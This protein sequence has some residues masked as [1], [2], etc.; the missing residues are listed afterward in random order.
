MA[1]NDALWDQLLADSM[2]DLGNAPEAG[3][4]ASL[5]QTQTITPTGTPTAAAMSTLDS[6]NRS[7]LI[8][9]GVTSNVSPTEGNTGPGPGPSPD[10]GPSVAGDSRL[11][12]LE[13]TDRNP[14]EEE[15]YQRLLKEAGG[16]S[17]EQVR[18][19]IK[20]SYD[21]IFQALDKR[22]GLLPEQRAAMEKDVAALAEYQESEA[23]LAR[24]RESEA[25]GREET[26]EKSRAAQTLRELAEDVGNL[27]RAASNVWGGSSAVPAVAR[28]IGKMATQ[29]R[30]KV[31]QARDT[32]LR[33][34]QSKLTDVDR[35][36]NQQIDKIALW[37]SNKMTDIYNKF[38]EIQQDIEN[39]K[40][41][42]SSEMA[43]NL[44]NLSMQIFT[45]AQQAM[46]NLDAMVNQYKLNMET[47]R[48]QRAG[49]LEDY[50]TKLQATAKY[51]PAGY[52]YM[53]QDLTGGQQQQTVPPGTLSQSKIGVSEDELWPNALQFS[54]VGGGGGGAG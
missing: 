30:G 36:F 38:V 20:A 48:E 15:E 14:V 44:A 23:E 52:S 13:K 50:I 5:S 31:L 51:T 53:M 46:Y 8:G 6:T 37:K 1:N 29:Q 42:A 4:S 21:P 16:Q 39:R 33:N 45:Q 26:G 34:I 54:S 3:A 43:A 41:T 35:T 47:W 19:D 27:L 49:E 17:S 7:P 10:S 32:A 12:Q 40:A 25:L 28:G 11:Q 9:G 24:T 22:L 18:A 2:S